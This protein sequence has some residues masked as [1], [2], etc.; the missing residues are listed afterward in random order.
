MKKSKTC[1][2]GHIFRTCGKRQRC[3]ICQSGY[4]RKWR[5]KKKGPPGSKGARNAKGTRS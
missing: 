2:Q 1:A 4:V 3:P 5:A